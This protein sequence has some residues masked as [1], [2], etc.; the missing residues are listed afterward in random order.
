MVPGPWRGRDSCR[1]QG[2]GRHA[3]LASEIAEFVSKDAFVKKID[4]YLGVSEKRIHIN[5]GRLVEVGDRLDR[6][7]FVQRS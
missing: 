7:T 3:Q 5:R 4:F 1:S 2:S 6:R